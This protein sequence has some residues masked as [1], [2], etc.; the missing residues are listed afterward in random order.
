[1]IELTKKK[2][3]EAFQKNIDYEYREWKRKNVTFRGIKLAG[4]ENGY[5]GSMM[6]DGLYTTPLSNKSMARKYGEVYFVVNAKPKKPKVLQTLND[7]EIF[8]QDI[9]N[10]YCKKHGKNYSLSFFESQTNMR[11]EVMK[12]GYDGILIKGREMVNYTPENV[13][14]FKTERQLEDY[15]D[16][17]Y[18]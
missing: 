1:M 3:I 13:L 4:S 8:T 15:Y 16:Y 5:Y 18:R 6:G 17:L 7:A 9:I 14:Y 10:K 2:L 12:L 11:D